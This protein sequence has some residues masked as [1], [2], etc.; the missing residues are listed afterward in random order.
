ME[1]LKIKAT[2]FTPEVILDPQAR[3][4]EFKGVSRPENAISFYTEIYNWFA[5]Y[6]SSLKK[7]IYAGGDKFD[8]TCDFHFSYFNS[9]S[10]K[11]I[12][13]ILEILKGIK[14]LGFDLTINWCYDSGDDQMRED[15]E[16]LS[17]AIELMFNLVEVE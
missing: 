10:S 5:D 6:E 9:S 8:L 12:Y 7:I 3:K 2:E 1:L 4:F 16:E 17:E 11:M 13:T 14:K 15:G